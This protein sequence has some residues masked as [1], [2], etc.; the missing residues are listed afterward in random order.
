MSHELRTPMNAILGFSQ[1]LDSDCITEDQH[2]NVREI[3]K[4]GEHLLD[5][6]NEILDL[7]KIES[8]KFDLFIEAIELNEVVKECISLIN[9]IAEQ[10]KINIIDHITA[11]SRFIIYGDRLRLKQVILNLFS[12]AI[13]YNRKRGSVTLTY[14]QLAIE[15]RKIRINFIDTG[16]GM[17][18]EQLA[19]LFQPFERLSAKNSD[20]A[21][22]GIGLVITKKLIE[23]MGGTIGVTSEVGQ[24]SCFWLDLPLISSINES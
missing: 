20:I 10:D 6:I 7:S 1:L 21:G 8:G 19:L 16:F 12:N 2:E 11:S 23:L 18:Q 24:G 9:P 14:M 4:A 5:L 15:E 13:K 17:T 22:T 3:L